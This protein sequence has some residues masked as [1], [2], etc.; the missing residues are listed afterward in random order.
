M[1]KK[2]HKKQ[3]IN[4]LRNNLY[5]IILS[6]F[7]K[8]KKDGYLNQYPWIAQELEIYYFYTGTGYLVSLKIYKY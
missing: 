1:V 5:I 2:I 3:K 6:F 4:N 8:L 7:N